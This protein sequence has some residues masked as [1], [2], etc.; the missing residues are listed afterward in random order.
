MRCMGV[1]V[2]CT[3]GAEQGHQ[4]ALRESSAYAIADVRVCGI[5]CTVLVYAYRTLA[6]LSF[7]VHTCLLDC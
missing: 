1:N 3:V 6:A 5:S 7:E 4:S 2:A